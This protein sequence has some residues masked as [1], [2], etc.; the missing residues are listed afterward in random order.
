MGRTA[1][2]AVA[3]VVMSAAFASAAAK[4]HTL[5]AD[6]KTPVIVLEFQGGFTPPRKNNEPALTI[7][8]DGTAI[9]GAP[10]GM[11]KRIEHELGEERLQEL[12]RY[13]LDEKKLG[14]FNA[15][16][17]QGEIRQ[18][19]QA[20]GGLGLHVADAATTS[21][22]VNADG[23]EM[24]AKYYAVGMVARQYPEVEPLAALYDVQRH[25]QGVMNEIYAGGPEGVA[26]LVKMANEALKQE[27]SAVPGFTAEHLTS[28]TRMADGR[29]SAHFSRTEELE[30]D[31]VRHS[32]ANLKIPA[33]GEPEVNAHVTT[34]PKPKPRK[35][36]KGGG[37]QA[38]PFRP[39]R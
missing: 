21:V 33:E 30:G 3:L 10:F 4:K 29:L 34:R 15:K 2:A 22:R 27:A 19:Q 20:K 24:E 17:V 39:A 23:K 6:P 32:S 8:A 16:D 1:A 36:G 38:V 12:L 5:P 9:L 25:L 26:R 13:I 7:R 11:R 35:P 14:E 18:I 37:I 31:R 28:A